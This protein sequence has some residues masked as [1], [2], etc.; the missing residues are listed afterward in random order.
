[1]GKSSTT[2][3]TVSIPPEVLARYNAVNARA[4]DVAKTPFKQYGTT[5]D[6]FVAPLT[7]AQTQG[8][9]Q[10]QDYA[11]AAQPYFQ[12]ATGQLMAAQQ[13]GQAQTQ[14]AYQPLMQGYQKG[15]A[16]G[17]QAQP[18]Y[19]NA[20]GV[21]NP[22]YNAAS[23][24]LGAGLQYAGN[25]QDAALMQAMGASG[26]A[27]GLQQYGADAIGSATSMAAPA[28]MAAMRMGLGAARQAQPYYQSATAGTQQ[29][30]E[31]G[32]PYQAL[33]TQAALSGSQ[34]INPQQFSQQAINQYMSPYM[35]NVVG[36][37]MKAQAQQ[38]AQQRQ[39][40]TGDA[41][42]AG[43]FG[44]DRAGI[45]Q[46]NL[47]YQQN[48]ANQ[49]T[50]ANLLQ[51]G[52]GQALG[53]FQ[54]QQGVN[55]QAEQANRAAQQ[56]LA[57]QAMAIG[58]QGYGQ[59]MGA[60]QQMAG[61]GQALYGQGMT[62]AQT[63]SG[64]GQTQYGQQIGAGQAAA[65][66]GQQLYGQGI[67][68]AQFLQGLGGQ[69]FQ[70]QLA[71]AQQQQAIGQGLAGL[72]FQT[73]QSLQG[74]GAQQ[75]QLA[76]QNAAQQ[77]QLAQQGYN[78]GANTSQALAGLGT[79]SQAAALQGAQA[80][81][82]AGQMQQQTEQAGKQAL[83][84]QFLQEQSYP[85]QTTQFLANIAMGTGALSG[86]TT[87]TTTPSA[88][89][90][91]RLKENVRKV[92]ETEKGLPIYKFRYKGEDKDQTHIG[93]MADEVEKKH[94]DAVGE[95]DGYK[96]V[97]YDK[98]NARESM[99]GAVHDGGLGR[100]AFAYGGANHIDPNDLNAILAQQRQMYGPNMGGL[101][102]TSPAE[103][104]R[105]GKANIP[106]G[107]LHVGK[108][109][110]AGAPPRS[111][112]R[113]GLQDA[114]GLVD[115]ATKYGKQAFGDYNPKT[116]K[117]EGGL[118][119]Q[120]KNLFSSD[121]SSDAKLDKAAS[122]MSDLD[123]LSLDSGLW[124]RGGL[125][126]RHGYASGAAI[127]YQKSGD[128]GEYF[129]EDV[130]DEADKKRELMTAKDGG[131]G[132]GGKSGPS[133][134][135]LGMKAAGTLANFIPGVGPF[136]GAGLNFASNLFNEGGVVPRQHYAVGGADDPELISEYLV[137]KESAGDPKARAKTSSA[138]GLGQ[139]TDATARTVLQRNPDIIEQMQR[140]GVQ[141]DP[142]QRGFT[143]QLPES[144]QRQMINA[145]VR[146][147]QEVLQKQGYEPTKE[148][149][150]MNWFLGEAGGPAFL[151]ALR[152]DPN[153]PATSYAGA[154]Q[155]RA[156]QPIF[157]NKDGT[158][159]TVSEVYSYLN[160]GNEGGGI[161]AG[162]QVAAAQSAPS[163]GAE[164]AE[165]I[166]KAASGF[167][168]LWSSL[169]KYAAPIGT[170][171]LT[172]ASSQSPHA[173]VAIAQ[174]IGAGLAAMQPAEMAQERVQQQKLQNIGTGIDL[175]FKGLKEIG[176]WLWIQTRDGR[177]LR[178]DKWIEAGEPEPV[179][180]GMGAALAHE[181]AKQLGLSKDTAGAIAPSISPAVDTGVRTAKET[182][183][184]P[185][186]EPKT[187]VAAAQVKP[188]TTAEILI[189]K[190]ALDAAKAEEM[191]LYKKPKESRELQIATNQA[192]QNKALERRN[193]AF[194]MT[195]QLNNLAIP[196][197]A[198]SAGKQITP[199]ALAPLQATVSNWFNSLVDVARLGEEYKIAPDAATSYEL[200][201]KAEALLKEGKADALGQR[202][203]SA[204]Q[205]LSQGIANPSMTVGAIRGILATNIMEKQ[206]A[207]EEAI[208]TQNYGKGRSYPIGQ[209][210][211]TEFKKYYTDEM[212]NKQAEDIKDL[213]A[214]NINGTPLINYLLPKGGKLDPKLKDRINAD[215]INKKYGY[216]ISRF[217]LNTAN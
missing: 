165:G 37:T 212:Y 82:G 164:A 132:G 84:N 57:Q 137:G 216:D 45:A 128:E 33:A 21:A 115:Q 163:Y 1:M 81:M 193:A 191:D 204:L 208:F 195:D 67:T 178:Y 99:G 117:Y 162:R 177:N 166:G 213:L 133:P 62:G 119:E 96:Y 20:I 55:L 40:L 199:G 175:G 102:G 194:G 89:S 3:Q 98:V 46:A 153:A 185:A 90:D 51:G 66:L 156:N 188:G 74:L 190:P 8:I 97:N 183:A 2:T 78:M 25:L 53:A 145:H 122:S 15:T 63:L 71:A 70:Q 103:M 109:A 182:V 146:Q 121:K 116:K 206:K 50:I 49:Q 95:K 158:P 76:Y 176:G 13:Q 196:L 38:N 113:G 58:Q 214:Q 7:Q 129:P 130:I 209:N 18:Y 23:S 29:A 147:Q 171:V 12:A 56:Q 80:M 170:G 131:G 150:R 61:L 59:Q 144:I 19:T 111:D 54:Q 88:W 114:A 215:V 35:S 32:A 91:R 65:Q 189:P 181:K 148:N 42:R 123:K 174:G 104:P 101:Y 16:L 11:L 155:V 160:K 94:P 17:D 30:V 141:Y 142:N 105:G 168:D 197:A 100:A 149:I 5:A 83:Y 157:F 192:I 41:I 124:A 27:S 69:G 203:V 202:A 173:R 77:A 31:A 187:Q 87:S 186:T 86:S 79:G 110:T 48:L 118:F 136:I 85:F 135:G 39:A 28:N 127:P 211:S 151:G 6:A 125:V 154:D 161:G 120:A 36:Q 34:A 152:D 134:I 9:Q 43:A 106:T 44:G 184:A 4:E 68:G 47:A 52:Y 10:T 60:A 64:L 139:F 201:K 112:K 75:A 172:A 24:G 138:A 207:L 73:G 200:A 143:A 180:G 210:A 167:G 217:F 126:P 179:G 93:Y 205:E 159:R 140:E 108:L 22:Y 72:Q 169:S 198:M 107:G 14:A 92:G 26:T